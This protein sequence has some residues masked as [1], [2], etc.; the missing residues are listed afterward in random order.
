LLHPPLQRIGH[1]VPR[2]QIPCPRDAEQGHARAQCKLGLCYDNGD[3]VEKNL[4]EAFRWYRKAAE[5]GNAWAQFKRGF[6]YA[7]GDGVEK[8][9]VEAVRWYRK[10]AEQGNAWAQN[11]LGSCYEKGTGVVQNDAQ[12]CVH[13]LIANALG[14]TDTELMQDNLRRIRAWLPGEQYAEAQQAATEWVVKFRAVAR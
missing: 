4:A 10:A 9:P 8:N 13:Y 3:G 14:A 5:Q 2:T 6:C 11:N 12:A 1:R 7:K